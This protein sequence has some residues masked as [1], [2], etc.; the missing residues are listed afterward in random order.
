MP[1]EHDLRLV[2]FH[3]VGFVVGISVGFF[4]QPLA[5]FERTQP[6][7]IIVNFAVLREC[8]HPVRIV[9]AVEVIVETVASVV[10]RPPCFEQ[11]VAVSR[12]RRIGKRITSFVRRFYS[13]GKHEKFIGGVGQ[14]PIARA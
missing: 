14:S 8:A 5:N 9:V 1:R 7:D 3:S 6:T 2:E 12:F 4:E 10:W 13:I 11:K